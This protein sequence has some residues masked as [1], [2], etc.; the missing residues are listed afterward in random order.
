[1]PYRHTPHD[2]PDVILLLGTD[3]SGKDHVANVLERFIRKRGGDVEKR[4]RYFSGR[5]TDE[6]SSIHK[7][8][9]DHLQERVFLALYPRMGALLPLLMNAMIRWDVARFSAPDKKLIVVG[10]NA[11]RAMAFHW[12]HSESSAAAF[13]IPTYLR[14]A[15][16]KANEKTGAHAI[17]LDVDHAVRHARIASRVRRR[18]ADSF[19]RYMMQDPARS[20]RIE[21]CLVSA[22]RELLNA[23][24]MI[25]NELLEEEI[26]AY[27]VEDIK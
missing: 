2:I 14:E 5:P 16:H 18:V 15:F 7:S 21:A 20:E 26:M 23:Q 17:V 25:N 1:M 9:F 22:A 4:K 3:A 12:G 10:H 13:H 11:L 8:F 19:D 27:V 24:T 6:A